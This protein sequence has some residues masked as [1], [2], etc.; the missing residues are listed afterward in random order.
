[1]TEEQLILRMDNISKNPPP[2][3]IY[4]GKETMTQYMRRVDAFEISIKKR[5]YD[6]I[7][8]FIN[9]AVAPL[10]LK[11][12]SLLDFKKVSETSFIVKNAIHNKKIIKK[13][14]A[15]IYK[16]LNIDIDEK[17]VEEESE[18]SEREENDEPEEEI[19]GKEIIVF[20]RRVLDT[21]DYSIVKK[22]M[23]DEHYYYI[24]NKP[25]YKKR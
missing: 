17:E 21:I 7:L 19:I 18:K 15:K 16:S 12:T 10:K 4:D 22:S 2:A 23:D 9:I 6:I 8:D 20:L 3:P 14:S 13:Y 25:V 1:M 11:Y 5:K 24:N